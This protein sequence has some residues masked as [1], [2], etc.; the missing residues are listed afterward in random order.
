M[1]GIITGTIAAAGFLTAAAVRWR[2]RP[3]RLR[4]LHA[5]DRVRWDQW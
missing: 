1:L 3:Q 5:V 4:G 2:R